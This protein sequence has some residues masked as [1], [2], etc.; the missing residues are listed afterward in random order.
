MDWR[1]THNVY[2][3]EE[4]PGQKGRVEGQKERMIG[5]KGG[6]GEK[7]R[8]EREDEEGQKMEINVIG[9]ECWGR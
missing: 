7:E 6:G 4:I 2:E 8:E 3:A 5:S 1:T 9:T